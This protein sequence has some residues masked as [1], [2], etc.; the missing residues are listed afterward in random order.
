MIS[1]IKIFSIRSEVLVIFL[2]TILAREALSQVQGEGRCPQISVVEDFDIARYLGRWYEIKS[3]P[4]LFAKAG[5]CAEANYGLNADGTVS[6]LN[7]QIVNGQPD[8]FEGFATQPEEGLGKFLVKF[9]Q[10]PSKF[11]SSLECFK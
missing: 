7:K 9:P 4:S 8:S 3:Y 6:V 1:F 10:I 5:K 11:Q 2:I